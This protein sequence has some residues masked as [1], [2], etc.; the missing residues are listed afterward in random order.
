MNTFPFCIGY[1]FSPE[2]F[3][4]QSRN[5]RKASRS[6][7][8][9]LASVDLEHVRIIRHTN[10]GFFLVTKKGNKKNLPFGLQI[11]TPPLKYASI[12]DVNKA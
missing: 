6:T 11:F 10:L 9:P 3:V 1:A 5:M 4:M 8:T 7:A 2:G 12:S